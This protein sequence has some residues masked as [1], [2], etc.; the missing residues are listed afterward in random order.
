MGRRRI[1]YRWVIFEESHRVS[2]MKCDIKNTDI[3][4]GVWW[5]WGLVT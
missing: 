4:E 1:L 2:E 5:L 3:G